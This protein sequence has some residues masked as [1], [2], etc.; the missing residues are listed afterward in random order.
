MGHPER[1]PARAG[2]VPAA[3]DRPDHVDGL[4]VFVPALD[5]EKDQNG[6]VGR[7]VGDERAGLEVRAGAGRREDDGG[8]RKRQ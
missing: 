4:G 6:L 1:V 8:T 5:V 2:G 7:A 3:G